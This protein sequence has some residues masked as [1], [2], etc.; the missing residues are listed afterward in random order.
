MRKGLRFC[1][2]ALLAFLAVM[3]G[4]GAVLAADSGQHTVSVTIPESVR[5]KILGGDI[6]FSV[7]PTYDFT[8]TE[9]AP[10]TFTVAVLVNKN[11]SWQVKVKASS[12]FFQ[13]SSGSSNKSVADL[14]WSMKESAGYA[15]MSTEEALVF[16]GSQNTG[17][18]YEVPLYYKLRLTGAELAGDYSV[19]IIYTLVTP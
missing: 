13:T 17:G 18:W 5:I 9:L 14:K 7:P 11:I 4:A 8:E 16:S 3:S 1:L 12:S 15:S 2:V 19:T 10:K 6:V